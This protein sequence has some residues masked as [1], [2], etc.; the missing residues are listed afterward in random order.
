M[1]RTGSYISFSFPYI[2][3]W[4]WMQFCFFFLALHVPK[5]LLGYTCWHVIFAAVI[6][7]SSGSVLFFFFFFQFYV[8][9]LHLNCF[10]FLFQSF[11]R[12]MEKLIE[13]FTMR[14][15]AQFTPFILPLYFPVLVDI[16]PKGKRW[17]PREKIN[18]RKRPRERLSPSLV[19]IGGWLK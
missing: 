18:T 6:T 11:S 3:L 14:A 12:R 10:S 15:C 1:S 13:L 9:L 19:K 7:L 4:R 8:F 2:D 17:Q 16:R 5:K